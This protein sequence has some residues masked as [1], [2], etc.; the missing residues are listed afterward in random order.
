MIAFFV[1]KMYKKEGALYMKRIFRLFFLAVMIC[2]I[3]TFF[4]LPVMA[5]GGPEVSKT[6]PPDRAI[7]VSISPNIVIYFSEQI[8]F[9]NS[10]GTII[11]K[12]PTGKDVS[13]GYGVHSNSIDMN[14]ILS[15]NTKYTVCVEAGV[16]KDSQGN[17]NKPYTFS[18]TTEDEKETVPPKTINTSP[19]NGAVNVDTNPNIVITFSERVHIG[20]N[21]IKMQD[22][23]GNN[24]NIGNRS[25]NGAEYG[26]SPQLKSGIKY[27][28]SIPANAFIDDAGNPNQAYS[29]S[30]TTK[31]ADTEGPKVI[32]TSPANSATNVPLDTQVIITFSKN[33]LKWGNSIP[34]EITNTS[35]GENVTGGVHEKIEANQ[36]IVTLPENLKNGIKYLVEGYK[37]GLRDASGNPSEAF[38]FSFTTVQ[39]ADTEGP[40]VVSTNPSNGKTGVPVNTK[41]AI[42]FSEKIVDKV[43]GNFY[44]VDANGNLFNHGYGSSCSGATITYEYNE[45]FKPNTKYTAMLLA[46]T[47]EDVSGNPCEPYSFSFT[48]GEIDTTPPKVVSTT[49]ANRAIIKELPKYYNSSQILVEFSENVTNVDNKAGEISVTDENG[50]DAGF[51]AEY[52]TYPNEK[53]VQILSVQENKTLKPGKYTV[54]IKEGHYMD[55]TGNKNNSY[56][57]SFTIAGEDTTPPKVVSTTPAN[58]ATNVGI[59]LPIKVQFSKKCKTGLDE[60]MRDLII[61]DA[62]GTEVFLNKGGFDG[63]EYEGF[64]SAYEVIENGKHIRGGY[65]GFKAN[66]RYTVTVPAGFAKDLNGNPSVEYTFTFTTGSSIEGDITPPTIECT[67][68]EG[69]VEGGTKIKL[70]ASDISGISSLSYDWDTDNYSNDAG[71]SSTSITKEVEVPASV[72][73]HILK[74]CCYDYSDNG[75]RKWQTFSF[76]VTKPAAPTVVS[77]TPANGA[78]N[79]SINPEIKVVF[80]KQLKSTD[81]IFGFSFGPDYGSGL[82]GVN[83]EVKNG[84]LYIKPKSAL[85]YGTKYTVKLLTGA[86][87]DVDGNKN[88]EY[89]FSFTTE[90]D[91]KIIVPNITF[92]DLPTNHWAYQAVMEMAKRGILN[93]YSDGTFRANDNVTRE[94]FAK[95]M[96]LAL[97]LPITEPLMPTFKDIPK[98]WWSYKYVESAK[99]YLTGY[100]KTDGL[101]FKGS[102]NAVREDMAYAL[103][104]AKGY[105]N[106]SVD[107]TR[108]TTLFKDANSVTNDLKKYVLIAYEKGIIRG[109]TDGTFKP[110]GTLTRAEA[111]KLL[112]NVITDDN[113]DSGKTILN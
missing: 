29:F 111:A 84:T 28:I 13:T 31:S 102:K 65:E 27:I 88:N 83:A 51:Y 87:T 48:T 17:P 58:G 36:L 40:K 80:S 3:A 9:Y 112:Y 49:P 26:F 33:N 25:L 71:S 38:C 78:T 20:S 103:V 7:N 39:A 5:E 96:V 45:P 98:T 108:L 41:I 24:I 44:I 72:G 34:F 70:K 37:D 54:K 81:E 11:I 4:A 104:K 93:G 62:S 77:T 107:M 100:R 19:I 91:N 12:D 68:S 42:K 99:A 94:E 85:S 6:Y 55:A 56:S 1:I 74:V 8:Y 43:N 53:T 67:P 60:A 76:N 97:N 105:E 50:N 82:I 16:V 86:V 66:T 30:F 106:T 21:D 79:T 63:Y 92:S 32:S 15:T 110:K 101:Y 35:T 57:F 59:G 14:P 73:I 18:F 109:Y 75:N 2:L 95:M 69:N 22:S 23:N 61:K 47:L 10:T 89:S 113:D 46:N 52:G 90:A 64:A